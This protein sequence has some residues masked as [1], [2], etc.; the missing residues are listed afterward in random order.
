MADICTVTFS[1]GFFTA[2]D[3][4]GRMTWRESVCSSNS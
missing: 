1:G 4:V 2:R 3:E